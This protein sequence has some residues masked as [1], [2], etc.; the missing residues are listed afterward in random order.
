MTS[1]PKPQGLI[2]RV[3]QT[4]RIRRIEGERKF[5]SFADLSPRAFHPGKDR[6][7]GKTKE[8]LSFSA[9]SV[10]DPSEAIEAFN[11]NPKA[12]EALHGRWTVA[13]DAS[14]VEQLPWVEEVIFDD[15]ENNPAHVSVVLKPGV[16]EDEDALDAMCSMMLSLAKKNGIFT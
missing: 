3:I 9:R 12:K 15:P 11:D 2:D 14:L 1:P 7:T 4:R 16:P 13:I 10:R 5:N 8:S 6:E